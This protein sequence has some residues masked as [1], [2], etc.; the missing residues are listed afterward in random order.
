MNVLNEL[1]VLN[2]ILLF[3]KQLLEDSLEIVVVYTP[4]IKENISFVSSRLDYLYK[5]I[6]KPELKRLR[7]QFSAVIKRQIEII[8]FI[9]ENQ[10]ILKHFQPKQLNNILNT[11]TEY[12]E[13]IANEN[14][15]FQQIDLN[16]N[17]VNESE[18]GFLLNQMSEK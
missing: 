5:L 13:N 16:N 18:Y 6:N 14:Y 4:L 10:S 3:I 2:R 15:D 9:L 7:K 12:Y 11:L 8:N 1:L 17:Y